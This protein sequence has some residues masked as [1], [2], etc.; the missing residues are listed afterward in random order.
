M[1]MKSC[2]P[3]VVLSY[4]ATFS[5]YDLQ[6]TDHQLVATLPANLNILRATYFKTFKSDPQV[7]GNFDRGGL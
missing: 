7:T 3:S 2:D 1:P 4:L 6:W 5:V